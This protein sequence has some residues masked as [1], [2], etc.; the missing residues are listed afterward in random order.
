[1]MVQ[2]NKKEN[3]R[4]RSEGETSRTAVPSHGGR[5]VLMENC[6]L[7]THHHNYTQKA[8]PVSKEKLGKS[9]MAFSEF[10]CVSFYPTHKYLLRSNFIHIFELCLKPTRLGTHPIR[11]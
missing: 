3:T 8:K 2:I 4:K 1:M 5:R 6:K 11:K 9:R 7:R 10:I